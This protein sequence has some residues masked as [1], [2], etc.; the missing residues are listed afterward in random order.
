[1]GYEMLLPGINEIVAS[2]HALYNEIVPALPT[3]KIGVAGSCE[4]ASRCM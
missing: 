3:G 2:M 1:M 4:V